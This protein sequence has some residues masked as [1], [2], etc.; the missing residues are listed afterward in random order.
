LGSSE[1]PRLGRSH[2]FCWAAQGRRTGGM[3]ADGDLAAIFAA[4]IFGYSGLTA[5]T[6]APPLAAH[7]FVP[8]TTISTCRPPH[9]EHTSR[10]RQLSTE[11][12]APYREA[13][14]AGSGST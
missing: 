9:R 7:R 12:S 13:I 4:D 14:S 2:G 1:D 11:V 10:W 3:T 6:F 8:V 5:Q